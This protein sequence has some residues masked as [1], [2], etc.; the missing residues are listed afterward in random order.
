MQRNKVMHKLANDGAKSGMPEVGV[1][2]LLELLH[3][4][5]AEERGATER[6]RDCRY[7]AEGNPHVWVVSY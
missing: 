5:K 4:V 2:T 7:E 3:D 6:H 1:E